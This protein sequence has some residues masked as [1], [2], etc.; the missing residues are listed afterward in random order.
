MAGQKVVLRVELKGAGKGVWWVEQWVAMKIESSVDMMADK[1]GC[2]LVD[3]LLVVW[4]AVVMDDRLVALWDGLKEFLLMI[5]GKRAST[6]ADSWI[7]K[8]ADWL[9]E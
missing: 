4:L 3:M 9:V 5:V 1:L 2:L 7:D 8:M 6:K